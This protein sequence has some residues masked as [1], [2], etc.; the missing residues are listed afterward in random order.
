M[1]T[2]ADKS[3]LNASFILYKHRGSI[4]SISVLYRI[5]KQVVAKYIEQLLTTDATPLI[6]RGMVEGL[7]SVGLFRQVLTQKDTK[8]TKQ[9][10]QYLIEKSRVRKLKD[11]V[12]GYQRRIKK[13]YSYCDFLWD[14]AL[15]LF[16]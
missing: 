16:N 13:T 9:N 2:Q 11:K 5:I 10:A 3:D 6:N 14:A 8:I 7:F 1:K 4:K 15:V 12:R